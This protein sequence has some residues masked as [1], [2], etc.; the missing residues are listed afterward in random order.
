MPNFDNR[1]LH[2][3]I[4][5]IIGAKFNALRNYVNCKVP[6]F[7]CSAPVLVKLPQVEINGPLCVACRQLAGLTLYI[8]DV[9]HIHLIF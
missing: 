8:Y 2:E 5:K 7:D 1:Y 3:D 6:I 9:S 4:T